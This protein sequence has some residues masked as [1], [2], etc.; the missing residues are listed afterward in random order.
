MLASVLVYKKPL[1]RNRSTDR[2]S[3]IS[4]TV[5]GFPR[6]ANRIMRIIKTR[7]A[8]KPIPPEMKYM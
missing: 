5:H 1:P 8:R 7:Q 6:R 4:G 3:A 2:N